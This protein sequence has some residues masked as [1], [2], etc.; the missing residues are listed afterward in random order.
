MSTWQRKML[1]FL[2]PYELFRLGIFDSLFFFIDAIIITHCADI[3]L[4]LYK[5]ILQLFLFFEMQPIFTKGENL[6]IK[7]NY[8]RNQAGKSLQCDEIPAGSFFTSTSRCLAMGFSLYYLPYVA[9]GRQARGSI[10]FRQ[11]LS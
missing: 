6:E 5:I 3:L 9:I 10:F 2:C 4:H 1:L 11:A 8:T 7:M